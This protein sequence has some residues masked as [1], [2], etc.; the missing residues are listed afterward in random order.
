MEGLRLEASVVEVVDLVVELT[1]C[2][3]PG[4]VLAAKMES[5]GPGGLGAAAHHPRVP[6]H[7]AGDGPSQREPGGGRAA[8]EKDHRVFARGGEG[9]ESQ[10]AGEFGVRVLQR[11]SELQRGVC[12]EIGM[13]PGLKPALLGKLNGSTEAEP[14][15]D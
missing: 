4:E 12:D 5:P 9:F 13:P 6:G 14:F 11:H 8:E 3:S 7:D 10:E 1:T 2:R 15:Q